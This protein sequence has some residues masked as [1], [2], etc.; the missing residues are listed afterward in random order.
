M[1]WVIFSADS[2][3]L[4]I[5]ASGPRGWSPAKTQRGARRGG[6]ERG[7]G[8]NGG[9]SPAAVDGPEGGLAADYADFVV[10]A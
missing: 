3:R 6:K 4:E 2:L 9:W 10:P 5:S 7:M 8:V 1:I